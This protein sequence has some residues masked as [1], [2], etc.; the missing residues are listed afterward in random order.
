MPENTNAWK[1]DIEEGAG[2]PLYDALKEI[3]ERV[4]RQE[5][6][7][8]TCYSYGLDH[9]KRVDKL[10]CALYDGERIRYDLPEILAALRADGVREGIVAEVEEAL[11]HNFLRQVNDGKGE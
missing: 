6:V 5:A 8:S 11:R 3:R 7:A 9:E 2:S 1:V 10:E 4:E